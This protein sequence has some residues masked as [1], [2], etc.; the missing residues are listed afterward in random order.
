MRTV[1][2][3]GLG[4]GCRRP[5]VL[6]ARQQPPGIGRRRVRRLTPPAGPHRRQQR[7]VPRLPG[8]ERLRIPSDRC[9]RGPQRGHRGTP[10]D[11]VRLPGLVRLVVHQHPRMQQ[12]RPLVRVESFIHAG[13]KCGR[14]LH[15]GEWDIVT[16]Q[17]PS[18]RR[19]VVRERD[20]HTPWTGPRDAREHA[21]RRRQ[22]RFAESGVHRAEPRVAV[23]PDAGA[24]TRPREH[25]V[26]ARGRHARREGVAH[27]QAAVADA[28]LDGQARRRL[29]RDIPGGAAAPPRVPAGVVGMDAQREHTHAG[30]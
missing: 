6:H 22:R 8:A 25:S 30:C 24:V 23:E 29:H 20:G 14:L 28:G 13:R 9:E 4:I 2:A 3:L 1:Q 10:P 17:H 11:H 12:R 7:T 26:V 15:D 19:A 5:R 21:A 16:Q 27:R 18:G